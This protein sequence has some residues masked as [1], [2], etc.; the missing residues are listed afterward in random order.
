MKYPFGSPIIDNKEIKAVVKVL[1]NPILVHGPKAE[2]F[3][4]DFAKYTG[5][6]KTITVS[7]CTAG[8]HLFYLALGL[9]KNDEVILPAQTHVATAH[10]VEA[11]GAKPVFIDSEL[12]TGNLDIK[13]L[14]KKINNKTKVVCVVHFLGNP[15]YMD[16][17]LK[18]KKKYNFFLIEDCA[19]SLGTSYKKKHTGLFGDIGVFSFYPVK[20]ITTGEGGMI[21]SKKN[22]QI[23]KKIKLKKAFG[24]NKNFKER[25]KNNQYDVITHGL[26][27]RMGE[28]NAAIGI[29]QLKKIE[30]IIKKR[31]RNYLY[32]YKQLNKKFKILTNFDYKSVKHSFYCL[33]ILLS[34]SLSKKRYQIIKK[35]KHY[36]I[37][38]S[39]YYPKPV[40]LMSYYQKKYKFT[41]NCFVNASLIS[42][43]SI[44]FPVGA[45]LSH[46]NIKFICKKIIEIIDGYN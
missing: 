7:S 13:E 36:G 18:L 45:H 4:K 21:I 31:K 42:S 9:K 23:L 38:T 15:V 24:V 35:L 44:S 33:S 20:L 10:A 37:G 25:L 5:A 43:N 46:K 40:P 11:V 34:N 41:K 39:I 1:K 19:L 32:M 28:I 6:K 14:K 27:Y 2:K 16:Q 12:E 3:E 22:S 29:E 30:N 26:N 8:L 17:I